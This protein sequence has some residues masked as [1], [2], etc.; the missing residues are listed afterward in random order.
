MRETNKIGCA[1]DSSA[2][3]TAQG[4]EE[5]KKLPGHLCQVLEPEASRFSISPMMVSMASIG[6]LCYCQ[7]VVHMFAE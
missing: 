4:V 6:R 3:R 2:E 5:I 1:D 7:E